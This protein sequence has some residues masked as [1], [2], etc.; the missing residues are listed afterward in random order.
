MSHRCCP[1]VTAAALSLLLAACA[2]TAPS[3]PGPAA[4]EAATE[5]A[6]RSGIVIGIRDASRAQALYLLEQASLWRQGMPR[7]FQ[8]ALD[9]L[10]GLDSETRTLLRK[11]AFIRNDL[12]ERERRQLIKPTFAEPCGSSGLWP[13]GHPGLV[14]KFWQAVL[15]CQQAGDL[16]RRLAGLLPAADASLVTR[17]LA[18]ITELVPQVVSRPADW[19]S[20]LD[21]FGR[22]LSTARLGSL[23]DRFAAFLG[24][25]SGGLRF[26]VLPVWAPEDADLA[27]AAYGDNIVVTVRQD[28]KPGLEHALLVLHEVGRRLLARLPTSVKVRLSAIFVES[29]GHRGAGFELAEA[30]LDAFSHGLAARLL[31]A[32]RAAKIAWPG[33]TRRQRLAR[34]TTGLLR[35]ALDT[36]ARLDARFVKRLARLQ[37][38]TNPPRPSDFLTGAM[39]IGSSAAIAAFRSQVVRWTVWKFP[40]GRRYNYPRKLDANAG[41]TV[42]CILTPRDLKRLFPLVNTVKPLHQALQRAAVRLKRGQGVVVAVPRRA[43]GFV[44][45]VAAPSP[46]KMKIAARAFF[47]LKQVPRKD[48]VVE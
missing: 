13:P 48:V 42:L 23:L 30:L 6:R 26:T 7:T 40:I 18:R 37:L 47:A 9:D 44:F 32:E 21:G 31:D 11:F 36:Q 4:A 5:A 2:S 20:E 10:V 17:A 19:N 27:A 25:D 14:E 41:R 28:E 33:D 3:R 43:R 29:A 12:A 45:V 16:P 8:R 38:E 46:E 1:W 39:V 22:R 34:T 24:V 35:Q 15:D